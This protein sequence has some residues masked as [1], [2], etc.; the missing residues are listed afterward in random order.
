MKQQ[1]FFTLEK[2]RIVGKKAFYAGIMLTILSIIIY[3][4]QDSEIDNISSGIMILS[5]YLIFWGGSVWLFCH[6]LKGYFN[7][8]I[9]VV[10]GIIEPRREYTG[11]A[12]KIFGLIGI[13]LAIFFFL[14]SF[15]PIPFMLGII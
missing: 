5:Y 13:I 2:L 9:M 10:G 14:L 7:R 1:K 11:K 4:A 12:A 6:S 3:L 15:L 8:K